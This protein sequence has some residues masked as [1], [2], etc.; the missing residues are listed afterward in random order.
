[1][2]YVLYKSSLDDTS[3]W[4]AARVQVRSSSVLQESMNIDT[5]LLL[6]L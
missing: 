1:M 2:L 6:S 5:V 3:T 4:E